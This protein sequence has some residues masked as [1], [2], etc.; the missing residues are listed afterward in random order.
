[1]IIGVDVGGTFTDFVLTYEG[2]GE[3]RYFKVPSTPDDPGR[4]VVDGLR[5]LGIDLGLVERL[6]HGTTVATNTVIQ[7]TGARTGLIATDG[8][9]DLL[10]IRRGTKP[11]AEVFNTTWSEPIPLVPRSRS[12]DVT[13]RVDAHGSVVE[14]LSEPEL[15]AAAEHLRAH[16]AEAVAIC[17]LFSF[18]N[19]EHE[20]A[21][22]RVVQQ[23]FP[24]LEVS[25]SSEILPQWREYERAV[26]TVADA[27]VKP[28]MKRYLGSLDRRLREMGFG[29][30]VL[31]MRSNG[32][33]MTARS[34]QERPIETFLSGPAGGVVAG[35]EHGR[36]LEFDHLIVSDV[37]GTSFDVSLVTAG[38]S[39]TTTETLIDDTTPLGIA[40]LDIRTIGAGGG[41]IAWIDAG[42]A[43]K[44]GPRSAGASP[45]PACYGAGGTEPTLTD[46][47]VVLGRIGETSLLGGRMNIDRE[48]AARAI[49]ERIADVLG[50][51]PIVAAYGIVRICVG[52]MIGEIRAITAERGVDPGG[53][54][55][56]AGGGA[57]PLHGVLMARELGM[58][59]VLIPSHPGL[60]SAGGL[61]LSDLRVD[62]LRSF[63]CRVE[64]DG[65]QSLGEAVRELVDEVRRGV[66]NEGYADEPVVEVAL[67]MK[68]TGQNWE[69]TVP[70]PS[71]GLEPGGVCDAFDELHQELY[72]FAIPGQSHEVLS[73]RATGIGPNAM[74]GV[75]RASNPTPGSRSSPPTRATRE[76]WDEVEGRFVSAP[77]WRR[78]D[79]LPGHSLSGP[80]VVEGMDSTIWLPCD[81]HALVTGL[82]SLLISLNDN[83]G[84]S[85]AE[86][87][88]AR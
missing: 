79:L 74:R 4:A 40:M 65:V 68:Y 70:V 63:R 21:A 28:A 73:I 52:N 5:E 61:V 14:P 6:I 66:R 85:R 69:I 47:N 39:K 80:G 82:S 15:I 62:R 49:R 3:R 42:G 88:L 12:L 34:A 48:L 22:K 55:L 20:H 18:M 44:V 54:V 24:E 56:L 84:T 57:G 16:G 36:E 17:F 38:S 59:L 81:S 58:G 71:A 41:S 8:H 87:Q 50:L 10:E 33:V 43:L 37:G 67:D 11:E 51:D 64:R 1:M 76:V 7:R 60:L 77:V 78:E 31:V 83:C 2:S 29:R 27:Y 25:I 45:G 53:Y 9:R 13:E 72:G 86:R 30:D 32:G 26:T 35:Q 75:T 19:P 23:L 46:A